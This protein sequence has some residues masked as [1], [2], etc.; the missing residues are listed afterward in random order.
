MLDVQMLPHLLEH[1]FHQSGLWVT[2]LLNYGLSQYLTIFHLLVHLGNV[3]RSLCEVVVHILTLAF[4]C[5]ASTKIVI[6]N[7]EV[8]M[9]SWFLEREER[10]IAQ[11]GRE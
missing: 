7:A 3:V 2:A 10:R 5:G 6:I 4:I 11:Y 8:I 9:N 1:V